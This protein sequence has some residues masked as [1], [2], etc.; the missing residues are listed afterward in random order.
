MAESEYRDILV[1]AGKQHERYENE[2]DQLFH[3]NLR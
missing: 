2:Q 1:A 3:G